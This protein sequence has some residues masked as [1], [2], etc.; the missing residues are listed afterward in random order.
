MHSEKR[1]PVSIQQTVGINGTFGTDKSVPYEFLID[2]R[3][4][5]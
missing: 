1:F 4:F 5:D 3:I 2:K